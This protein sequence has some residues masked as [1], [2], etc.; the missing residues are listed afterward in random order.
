MRMVYF[1]LLYQGAQVR[2]TAL[3]F[4]LLRSV[5]VCCEYLP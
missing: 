5:S 2:Y 3:A 4:V 1:T